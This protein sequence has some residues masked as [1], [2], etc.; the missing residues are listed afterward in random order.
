MKILLYPIPPTEEL[1][2]LRAAAGDAEVVVASSE[3]E[4]IERIADCDALYGLIKPKMLAAGQK[5]RWIQLPTASMEGR[6]FPELIAHPVKVSN[7]RGIFSD[8]IADHVIGYILCFARGLHVYIRAQMERRWASGDPFEVIHLADQTLG[9]VGLG[10]IGTA[11]AERAK[12]IGMRVLATDL[13]E[14]S[15]PPVVDKLWTLDGLDEML[16]QSDFV[17]ITA[18]HTPTSERLFDSARFTTM[19]PSAYL[20]NVGRGVIVSLAALTAA[21][22]EGRIA[23]AALDVFEVEPLPEDSEL[24]TMPNVIIT[25]HT[26]GRSPHFQ[27]RRL[28]LAASNI[29]RFASGRT[30][31][32]L[33]D[34]AAWC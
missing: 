9:I 33:V 31:A 11:V 4:A 28:E 7:M 10:G 29:R 12:V 13:R 6:V 25:P 30:P 34:K 17:A 23:G 15:R 16:A 3:D 22:K 27:R 5:L 21:L 14:I 24:W 1:D 8:H 20:I 2:V 18:P 32:N 19:K 26:A